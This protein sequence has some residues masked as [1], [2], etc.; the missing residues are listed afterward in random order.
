MLDVKLQCWMPKKAF[1]Q[2]VMLA[3]VLCVPMVGVSSVS[4]AQQATPISLEDVF[5]GQKASKRNK[6]QRAIFKFYE[7]RE[8]APFWVNEGGLYKKADKLIDAL[9]DSWT[10]GL[11]PAHYN[12]ERIEELKGKISGEDARIQKA[13]LELLLTESYLDYTRDLSGMRFDRRAVSA[14]KG[15]WRMAKSH[16]YLLDLLQADISI[17]DIFKSLIPDSRTYAKLRE[18]LT[19]IEKSGD[20]NSKQSFKVVQISKILRPGYAHKAVPDLRARFDMALPEGQDPLLYDDELAARVIAFQRD[21]YLKPDGVIGPQTLAAINRSPEKKKQQLIVNMERLRWMEKPDADRYVIVNIPSATLWAIE[22]KQI[23]LQMPVIVG[24]PKRPTNSF[25]T[26][27]RGVRINPTWTIPP[28]IKKEDIWPKLV[29]DPTYVTNKGIEI[30]DGY[31]RN[32]PTIDPLS[33]DWANVTWSQVN[34]MRMVQVPGN[35]NPLG[36]FRVLMPN[37]YDIYLHDTNRPD[38]FGRHN[39][40]LSSG[41]IRMYDPVAMTEF[42]FKDKKWSS[43]RTEKILNSLKMTDVSAATPIPVYLLYYTVWLDNKGNI[44]YGDDMY[45]WDDDVLA[46][47]DG[48][49][50]KRISRHNNKS[51]AASGAL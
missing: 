42:I 28:T 1:L 5:E 50:E 10:H 25:I 8:N 22:D 39:R 11:N 16:N 45:G 44:V 17:D 30:Y 49:D 23:A 41:C 46:A 15:N 9:E 12:L 21:E 7:L 14:G 38:Y 48:V 37:S 32:A 36:R 18:A 27:I 29:S 3:G 47:L 34:L 2:A 31:G 40:D 4:Y 6:K 26:E 33:V 24:K 13:G 20:V 35:H 51:S 43:E 19:K